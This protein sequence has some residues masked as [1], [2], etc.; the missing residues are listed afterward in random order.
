M[1][2]HLDEEMQNLKLTRESLEKIHQKI[3]G[4]YNID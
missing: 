3:R 4:E 2:R 1:R